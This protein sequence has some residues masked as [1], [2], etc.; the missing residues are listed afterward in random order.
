MELKKTITI[1]I[2]KE[3]AICTKWR[4]ITVFELFLFSA[5]SIPKKSTQKEVVK[6]VSAESVVAKVAAVSPKR[7]TI[8]GISA[9]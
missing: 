1:N 8:E 3:N 2:R 7:K 4:I 9:R 5:L 6:A